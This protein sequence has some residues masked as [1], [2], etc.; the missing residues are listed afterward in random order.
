M[1]LKIRPAE[2]KDAEKICA[3]LHDIGLLH[4]KGRPDIY[5]ENLCKYGI[6][7]IEAIIENAETP[8]LCAVSEA[9]EVVG[10]AFMQYREVKDDPSRIDRKYIYIDDFCVDSTIRRAGIGRFLM[11]GVFAFAREKGYD[12]VELN[13]WEFNESAVRFYE[14]CGM[15]TQRRQMEITL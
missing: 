1:E 6:P 3:M 11:N 5:R 12:K 7:E 10:Y 15:T 4:E 8:I 9:D 2:K 14:S 13:V